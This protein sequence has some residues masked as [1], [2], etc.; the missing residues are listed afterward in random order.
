MSAKAYSPL[1]LAYTSTLC[2]LTRSS[3]RIMLLKLGKDVKIILWPNSFQ[4]FRLQVTWPT[5]L[6][7]NSQR[8]LIGRIFG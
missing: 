1:N 7:G 2:L 3:V 6:G 4:G 5:L 8:I